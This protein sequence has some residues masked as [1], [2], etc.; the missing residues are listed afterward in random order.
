MDT[1]TELVVLAASISQALNQRRLIVT[2]ELTD[3]QINQLL[4]ELKAGRKLSAVKLCKEWTGRSLLESK[5]FVESLATGQACGTNDLDSNLAV[6]EIDRI[7]DAIQKG[8]KLDAIKLYKESSGL[9]LMESKRFV[10]RLM[11]E[12]GIKD[13]AGCTAIA[14]AV[15]IA[16]AGAIAVT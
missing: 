5:N 2:N 3:D 13:Q 16:A 4:N 12:L 6:N 10:E 14:L 1:C 9:S 15:I 7:L 11:S 8:K